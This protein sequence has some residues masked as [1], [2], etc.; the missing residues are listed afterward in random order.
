[1][2]GITPVVAIVLLMAVTVAAAGTLW[3]MI[4]DTQESAQENAPMIE[5]NTD[6]LNVESCWY[7]NAED[8]VRLQIRNEHSTDALNISRVNYYYEYDL[9]E[10][11]IEGNEE[12]IGP[13]RSWRVYINDSSPEDVPTI[14]ISNQGNTMTHRCFNLDTS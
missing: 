3:T 4:E 9:T 2:K 1:M 8:Q 11:D 6:I 5:F 13:Q 12:I 10:V 7:N 14:E